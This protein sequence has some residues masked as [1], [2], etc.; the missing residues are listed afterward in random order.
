LFYIESVENTYKNF[1]ELIKKESLK[2]TDF[3]EYQTIVLQ[4]MIE[5]DVLYIDEIGAIR[6]K[7]S[8]LVFI[9]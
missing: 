9:L 5:D 3:H 4:K 7:D 6:I 2:I 1:Y 8:I